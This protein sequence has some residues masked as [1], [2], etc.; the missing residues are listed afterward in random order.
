MNDTISLTTVFSGVA[1]LM[2]ATMAWLYRQRSLQERRIELQLKHSEENLDFALQSGRMGTWDLQL[3]DGSL[4]C[5]QEMLDL[6]GVSASEYN[7]KRNIFQSK[8]HPDDLDKM[9]IAIDN[10]IQSDGLYELEYR[11]FPKPDQVS[12]V[13]SRGRCFFAPGSRQPLRFSGVVF[14]VTESREREEALKQAIQIRDRFLTIAGHELRTPLTNL[15]LHIQLRQRDLK[16]N[17]PEAFTA[18]K[19]SDA[20]GKEFE[21]V[22]RLT[23]LVDDMLDAS[24]IAEGHLQL[25]YEDFDLCKLVMDVTERFPGVQFAGASATYG[26]W[27]RFR[28]EQVL[29][30]LLMNALKYGKNNAVEVSLNSTQERVQIVVRDRGVGIPKEDQARVFQRFERAISENEVSGLGLGLYIANTIVQL[31]GGE[32]RLKSEVGQ[33]SEFTVLLPVQRGQK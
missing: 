19:I 10:A 1:T 25:S 9:K 21:H 15:Q 11:I 12:W 5:S 31:H 28:L 3:S 7:N 29:V 20:L 17:Y 26:S 18:E 8:V 23:R 22:R 6:W 30:N 27:D 16:R 24:K 4:S 33:G 2:M 13:L 14:D 32:I